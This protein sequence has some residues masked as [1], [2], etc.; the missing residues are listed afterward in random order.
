MSSSLNKLFELLLVSLFLLCAV[1]AEADVPESDLLVFGATPGGLA[2]GIAAKRAGL[3]V[4]VLEPSN[5][6]GGIVSGGLGFSDTC[7][8]EFI[9]GIALE[10][11]QRVGREYGKELQW[12]LVPSVAEKVF[13]DWLSEE[14][15]RVRYG[16]SLESVEVVD[17]KIQNVV[18][19]T[20]EQFKALNFID[21]S[22]TGDLLALAGVDYALGREG[23]SVYGESLAGFTARHAREQFPSGL[24]AY[25]KDGSL[26]HGIVSKEAIEIGA[27]DE[28]VMAYNY[29][30]CLT[31][32]KNNLR[33]FYKPED[34][35]PERY[36][37]LIQLLKFI[38][39]LGLGDILGLNP[40]VD[41][42]YDLNNKGPF[43]TN[44]LNVGSSYSEA[45]HVERL[46]I[47]EEHA[48]HIKGLLYFLATDL[49]VPLRIR[50]EASEFGYC[51]DEFTSSDNFPG[52]IYIR[53]G[54]R[55]LGEFVLTQQE[56]VS[57]SG[58]KDSIGWGSCRIEVHHNQ[59]LV[60]QD[61]MVYN[62][63][64][65]PQVVPPYQIPY[66]SLI[67]AKGQVE[68]LLVPVAL[69][70][71]NIA[72]SSLRMEPQFMTFGQVAGTA[73]FL[74]VKYDLSVRD[75]DAGLLRSHLFEAGAVPGGMFGKYDKLFITIAF[76][77][78]SLIMGSLP[79]AIN[80]GR[81]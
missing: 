19:S 27:Q 69:S 66:R 63:G 81:E 62:E 68:N 6:P 55:M 44:L 40:T 29:R 12:N 43:S 77:V 1:L 70:A 13:R 2:A 25:K 15:L 46:K 11:F 3:S 41:S 53:V 50:E 24:S 17:G 79:F 34:Y 59:R 10:F 16:I 67:P 49:S 36:S 64:V 74:S 26:H 52:Q 20:G 54:R 30:P 4:T 7:R 80:L 48:N 78:A 76:G 28:R 37:L 18:G 75:I 14:G 22:Y 42:K 9:G 51:A 32:Q 61:G 21:A 56:L 45:S 39:D 65:V 73:A 31:K 5:I 33:K 57:G 60:D 71:S 38:P 47:E 72:Y 8:K 23:Q 35:S 58:Q